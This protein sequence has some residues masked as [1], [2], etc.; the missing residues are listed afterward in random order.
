MPQERNFDVCVIGLGYIGLPTATLIAQSDLTVLG[1]DIDK[2]LVDTINSGN[3]K[4]IEPE[5]QKSV[6]SVVNS[7]KFY[8]SLTPHYSDCFIIAVPTPFYKDQGKI[9]TPNIEYVMAAVKSIIAYLRPGN[10]IIIESTCPVGTTSKI[11]DLLDSIL[12]FSSLDLLVAY[13]PER[14]LPGQILYELKSNDRVIGGINPDSARSAHSIYST[15]CT[16]NLYLTDAK[17]AE[18]VKLVENSFRDV[19][20][21]FANEISILSDFYNVNV[22]EVIDLSNNHPRVNI[23]NPGCGVG[24]HC[25]AVDPWFIASTAPD[26]SPLIQTARAV[27]NS[28][29]DFVI[30]KIQDA[31]TRIALTKTSPI[32]SCMGISYKPNVDDCRESAALYI[33]KKIVG[34]YSNA[35]VCEPNI[36]KSID[37]DLSSIED[38]IKNSDLIVFLVG[39]RE[40]ESLVL[41]STTEILDFCYINT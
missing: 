38:C 11:L 10:T 14:V 28:K 2:N 24:G 1:V 5:L 15:F 6:K 39:H 41:P 9:P 13:C 40:F 31:I 27:N 32:V 7:G 25:I 22:K 20:I 17:T 29:P 23:L 26:I 4:I 34:M 19:N 35:L 33:A 3:L 30:S 36:D 21:A 8:A 18:F 37:V 12:D 16:A